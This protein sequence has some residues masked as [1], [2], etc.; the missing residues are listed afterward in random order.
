MALVI[1]ARSGI[2]RPVVSSKLKV[3]LFASV[4]VLI[5]AAFLL[6]LDRSP[7]GDVGTVRG[8]PDG[9]T[10]ELRQVL[11]AKGYQYQHQSGNRFTR[12]VAPMTPAFIR[13]RF[14]PSFSGS[15]GFGGD[16]NTNLI[17]VTV[18]RCSAPNW[19]S[20]LARLRVFDE[21]GNVYDARW[22]SHTL[23]YPG[24]IVHGWQIRA[25]PRRS[26]TVGLSFLAQNPDGSWTNVCAFTIRNPASADCPQWTP[27]SRPYTKSDGDLAVTLREFQ[28]G[29]R[30]SGDRG[31]GDERTA[32]RKTR[33]V[34]AFAKDRRPAD[35]WRVQKLTIADATGNLWS[36][37]LDFLKQDF[38]W[39]TN[40]TVEF[41]GA[42]WPGEN[43]WKLDAE[44]VRISG[45]NPDEL[46][47]APPMP[48]PGPGLVTDLTN[49]WQHDGVTVQ[50]VSVASPNTDH[51]GGFK[52]IAKWWGEDKSKVFS[53]ALQISPELKNR[54][55]SVARVLDQDG[56]EVEV[57]QH[58]N[59]DYPQQALFLKPVEAARELRLTFALQQS[60]FVQFLA[61]P[62]FA[63][64]SATNSPAG[65][66]RD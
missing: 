8:L 59:Q 13:N 22:G 53:I 55:L 25:F 28:S 40:C 47:E 6:A 39:T 17:V 31:Q 1:R 52:W 19:W 42:L 3:A 54:R 11:F 26:K 29:G 7:G 5:V 34:F 38:D 10:L 4:V 51:A 45:F 9:S 27:E 46:W 16:E 18:N 43:A 33:V 62:E 2:G 49:S 56:R 20:S 63:G 64:A 21:Q 41:F 60:R 37:Y 57:V 30:M 24:E 35:N 48:L 15:F 66:P 58:G 44:F 32:A 12:F 23:G 61:R 14:F 65:L 36:P 50:L